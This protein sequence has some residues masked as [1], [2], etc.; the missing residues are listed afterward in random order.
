MTMRNRVC[1]SK[2][3]AQKWACV[4]IRKGRPLGQREHGLGRL[5]IAL[6]WRVHTGVVLAA[7]IELLLHRLLLPMY[8]RLQQLRHL[9]LRWLVRRTHHGRLNECL[10]RL[11]RNRRVCRA[12]P[13]L[14]L[15]QDRRV[16]R[17][18]LF[19]AMICRHI[20]WGGAAGRQ[21]GLAGGRKLKLRSFNFRLNPRLQ[22][23]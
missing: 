18:V 16:C 23:R 12:V 20:R 8:L 15:R 21:G 5:V 4:G 17:A 1:S 14:V 22:Q 10:A 7:L 19:L 9:F 3:S 6:S 13:F 2:S 11:R